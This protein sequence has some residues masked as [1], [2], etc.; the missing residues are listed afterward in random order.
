MQDI[1]CKLSR[2]AA[3]VVL[4][5]VACVG[6]AWASGV[7]WQVGDIVVCY[8]GG[9]CN[10][11]RLHGNTVQLL[12]TISSGLLGNNG[13]VGLNNTL[14]VLATDDGGGGSSKV[15]V[16]SIASINPFDPTKNPLTHTVISTFNAAGNPGDSAAAVAVSSAGHI[17]V[18]NSNATGASIVELDAHGTPVTGSTFT[19]PGAGSCPATTA[20]S[21]L[22]LSADGS[23]IYV[24]VAD[25]VI[26]KVSLALV[27]NVYTLAGASCAQFAN[28]GSAL[29]LNAL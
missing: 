29:N 9:K 8:G 1:C 11:I 17:F 6:S 4:L 20:I 12:D 27:T 23:A 28:F 22:D 19:F 16:Y 18:G 2:T 21:S 26:R 24:T 3:V 13:G 25:G 5:M 7:P 10:V 14:H 15:V